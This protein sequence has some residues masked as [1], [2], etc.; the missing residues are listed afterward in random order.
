MLKLAEQL[1][2]EPGLMAAAQVCTL[3]A[4]RH[5]CTAATR[6]YEMVPTQWIR[7]PVPSSTDGSDAGKRYLL[8]QGP[9]PTIGGGF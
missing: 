7:Q 6:P 5:Q 2:V 9:L 4:V 8:T 3:V 1:V